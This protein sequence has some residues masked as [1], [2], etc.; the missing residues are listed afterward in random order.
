MAPPAHQP[1]L[2]IVTEFVNVTRKLF[3]EEIIPQ[4]DGKIKARRR[5]PVASR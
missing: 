3:K 5:V 4:I 1:R 2:T